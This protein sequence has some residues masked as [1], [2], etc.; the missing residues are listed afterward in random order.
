MGETEKLEKCWAVLITTETGGKQLAAY[1]SNDKEYVQVFFKN[2]ESALKL[3][4]QISETKFG[5]GIKHIDIITSTFM[6]Y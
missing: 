5:V 4:Q 2:K 1:S 6:V 3:A